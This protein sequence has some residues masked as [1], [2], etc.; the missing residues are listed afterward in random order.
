MLSLSS[1]PC[2]GV[3]PP[4]EISNKD[5][6]DLKS[7]QIKPQ[8]RINVHYKVLSKRTWLRLKQHY[9]GGPTLARE[10]I[11]IYSKV[12]SEEDPQSLNQLLIATKEEYN[13]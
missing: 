11:D 4:G 3:L 10:S 1:N 7:Q 6:F 12:V 9:G 13:L 5:L 2:I 8:L